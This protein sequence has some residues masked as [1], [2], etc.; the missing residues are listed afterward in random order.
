MAKID[1]LLQRAKRAISVWKP[2]QY[3]I[4]KIG[5]RYSV[6]RCLWDGIPGSLRPGVA[7]QKGINPRSEWVFD[8]KEDAKKAVRE[9]IERFEQTYGC[10]VPSN[11]LLFDLCPPTDQE[12]K[13]AWLHG[14]KTAIEYL[15]S[16]A[17]LTVE[18]YIRKEF[19]PP[20]YTEQYLEETLARYA[21]V[22]RWRKEEGIDDEPN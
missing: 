12:Q 7:E 4:R 9:D 14:R 16:R 21:N 13:E 15:A 11:L 6:L 17:G 5:N 20:K 22:I 3:T 19:S 1:K 18:A 2:Y 10:K 8:S